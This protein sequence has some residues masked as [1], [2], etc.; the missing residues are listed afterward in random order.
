MSK[1]L[2]KST[3]HV[4]ICHALTHV[5]AQMQ[6]HHQHCC[7]SKIEMYK[8]WM[9]KADLRFPY[10]STSH[11]TSE[12]FDLPRSVILTIRPVTRR[13]HWKRFVSPCFNEVRT[14]TQV[15]GAAFGSCASMTKLPVSV[16]T[17]EKIS[18]VVVNRVNVGWTTGLVEPP[19]FPKQTTIAIDILGAI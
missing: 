7:Y 1:C 2:V 18:Q 19:I 13:L 8:S 4:Y 5:T 9:R 11:N 12:R 15:T 10:T 17:F 14:T 16:N 6:T 3:I